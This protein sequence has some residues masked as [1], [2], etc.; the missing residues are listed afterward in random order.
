MNVG[1]AAQARYQFSLNVQ[2]EQA[3]HLGVTILFDDVNPVVFFDEFVDFL[4][5]SSMTSRQVRDVLDEIEDAN[6]RVHGYG[7]QNFGRNLRQC[8]QHLAERAIQEHDLRTV[9]GFAERIL[10]QPMQVLEGVEETLSYLSRRHDLTLFTKGNSEE[11]K[12]KI[13]QSGL[14][15]FFGHTAIVK[16]KD[17]GAYRLLVEERQMDTGRTWMI[18][19]S[20]KSDINPALAAGL[21]A[22]FVPHGDTWILEHEEVNPAPEGQKLLIVG[23]FAELREHF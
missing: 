23:R 17:A 18:G 20:P 14:G 2:L 19:N 3:E 8:Y 7:S 9:M 13:A 15:P 10:E 5:H 11:Q 21:H 4:A 1:N 12:L 16:E 22:I 6:A